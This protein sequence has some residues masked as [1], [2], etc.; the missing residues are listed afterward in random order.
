MIMFL[1]LFVVMV[2]VDVPTI[3]GGKMMTF[4]NDTPGGLLTMIQID[5]VLLLMTL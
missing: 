4:G 1:F 3:P 2:Q 5:D